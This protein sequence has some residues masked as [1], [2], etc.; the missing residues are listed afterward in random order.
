MNSGVMIV[1]EKLVVFWVV[2]IVVDSDWSDGLC[3]S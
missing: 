2:R 3:L 1:S